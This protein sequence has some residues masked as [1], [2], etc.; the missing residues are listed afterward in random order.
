MVPTSDAVLLVDGV[1]LLR[2]ELIGCWDLTVH[3][4]I[5]D[6]EVVRRARHRDPGDPDEI[7]SRY[8]KRCLPAQEICR[9]ECSPASRADLVIDNTD[10]RYPRIV[11]RVVER[12]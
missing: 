4:V 1:F 3:L 5:A 8:R 10:P 9:R 12:G 6:E 11:S 2:P 7:E